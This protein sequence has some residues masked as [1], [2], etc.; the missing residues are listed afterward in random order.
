MGV[1]RTLPPNDQLR[2]V[3]E[4]RAGV[5]EVAGLDWNIAWE[6]HVAKGRS[7][8]AIKG[9]NVTE[10]VRVK[11]RRGS[12]HGRARATQVGCCLAAG[13]PA[14][15]NPGAKGHERAQGPWARYRN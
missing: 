9:M 7:Q 6:I 14:G 13:Y 8:G 15:Y 10:I 2:R 12:C 4:L 3:R 1:G 5:R 11:L